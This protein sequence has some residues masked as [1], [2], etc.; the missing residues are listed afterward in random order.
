MRQKNEKNGEG[1]ETLLIVVHRRPEG[2]HENASADQ[3]S[4]DGQRPLQP[5]NRNDPQ[6]GNGNEDG[7]AV[8]VDAEQFEK[9]VLDPIETPAKEEVDERRHQPRVETHE[10]SVEGTERSMGFSS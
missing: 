10:L 1:T 8:P 6:D 5:R 2:H 4:D 9:G 3:R 7:E